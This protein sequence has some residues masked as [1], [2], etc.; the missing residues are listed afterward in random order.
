VPQQ[1]C[2]VDQFVGTIELPTS[3]ADMTRNVNMVQIEELSDD[4]IQAARARRSRE[5]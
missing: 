1:Q 4:L 5:L 2:V 3:H